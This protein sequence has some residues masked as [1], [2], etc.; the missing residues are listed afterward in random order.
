MMGYMHVRDGIKFA[1]QPMTNLSE[2]DRGGCN[3]IYAVFVN[4]TSH[5]VC[6]TWR[7]IPPGVDRV[8][9]DAT[10]VL[11]AHAQWE[12]LVL[13]HFSFQLHLTV[14]ASNDEHV[15]LLVT[16]LLYTQYIIHHR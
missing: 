2:S 1:I 14:D 13:L 5:A 12:L 4:N 6:L 10:P 16:Q 11:L 3:V 8:S 15:E 7:F 9:L